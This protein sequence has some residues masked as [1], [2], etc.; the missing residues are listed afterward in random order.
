MEWD[1][2]CYADKLPQQPE[3]SGTKAAQATKASLRRQYPPNDLAIKGPIS[4]PCI[5]VDMQGIILPWYL[6]GIL[7]DS[8]QVRLF[9]LFEH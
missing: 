4:R 3:N 5:I 9:T 6:P 2:T 8:Q 1:I 7:K